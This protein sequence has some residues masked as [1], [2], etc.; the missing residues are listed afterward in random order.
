MAGWSEMSAGQRGGA[1]GG[2]VAVVAL[3][4]YGAWTVRAKPPEGGVA[5]PVAEGAAASSD[6]AAQDKTA[7]DTTAQDSA[8]QA[9]AEQTGAADTATAPAADAAKT[10]A[11]DTAAADTTAADSAA[12]DT[13]AADTAA[14]EPAPAATEPA[15]VAAVAPPVFDLVRVERD[16]AALVA[17]TGA[18][19]A[20]ISLRVN[21]DEIVAVPADGSGK[22]VAMFNLPPSEAA[23]MLGLVMVMPDGTEVKA[24]QTV[25]I[26]PTVAPV[27]VAAGGTEIADTPAAGET[28]P[29]ALLVTDQ[30]AKVLQSQDSLPEMALN[31]TVDSIS[32]SPSGDVQ[33]AG[34]G[35]AGAAVRVYLDNSQVGDGV[36]AAG[37]DWSLT[38]AGVAPGLYTLRVDQLDPAGKVTSR[39]ETPFKR[40]TLEALAAASGNAA[41]PE[42]GTETQADAGADAAADTGMAAADAGTTAGAADTDTG[43]AATGTA[44]EG[45]DTAQAATADAAATQPDSAASADAPAAP[46]SITVQPGFSLW[47]IARDTLGE[48]VMYVQVFEANKAQIKDPNLIY[49]G[50]VFTIPKP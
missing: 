42:G 34:R 28:A 37:G 15:P 9:G 22:F 24:T 29:A 12:A 5:A 26:A 45:A 25:A 23:R 39:F 38:L 16:G 11:E 7:P 3:L 18:A 2:V 50:Q 6:G 27:V 17:G 41:A 43:T 1:V 8:A 4:L 49:P 47:A 31:V 32:Y 48:G 46:V 14:A 36:V 44:T 20:T 35:G 13:A 33:L 30:G 21:G 19:G 10:A 40:E